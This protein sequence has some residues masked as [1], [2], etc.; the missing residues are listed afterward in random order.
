MLRAA[1]SWF[2]G[3]DRSF[4]WLDPTHSSRSCYRPD[5]VLGTGM[6]DGLDMRTQVLMCTVTRKMSAFNSRD[7]FRARGS[8]EEGGIPTFTCGS[9]AGKSSRKMGFDG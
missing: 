9:N 6:W 5:A 4:L 2:K 3:W 7:V 1:V 8:R